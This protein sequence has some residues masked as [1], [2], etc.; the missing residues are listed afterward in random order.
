MA[1]YSLQ[2]LTIV[3]SNVF[4]HEYV[5]LSFSAV[6]QALYI[7]TDSMANSADIL[8]LFFIIILV[9]QVVTFCCSTCAAYVSLC[10]SDSFLCLFCFFSFI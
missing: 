9:F 2:A 8:I 3:I 6:I 4:S 5:A 1:S 7:V 10:S